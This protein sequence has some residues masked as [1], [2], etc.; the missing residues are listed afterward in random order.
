MEEYMDRNLPLIIVKKDNMIYCR[1]CI[2][3]L[4]DETEECDKICELLSSIE[5]DDIC[6]Y[7]CESYSQKRTKPIQFNNTIDK[8][9]LSITTCSIC[10]VLLT[11][12][13]S[14]SQGKQCKY[15]IDS[16]VNEYIRNI[17]KITY[18]SNPL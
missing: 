3:V 8:I 5:D 17:P 18:V 15:N 12:D 6:P 14:K 13:C 9:I 1:L 10:P 2:G 7:T 16:N 11:E 4:G